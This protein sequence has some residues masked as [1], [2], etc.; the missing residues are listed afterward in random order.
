MITGALSFNSGILLF[1]DAEPAVPR[2]IPYDS[3]RIFHRSYGSNLG[4]AHSVFAA[5]ES[6]DWMRATIRRCESALDA[7]PSVHRTVDRM[8]AAVDRS[9]RELIQGD[10]DEAD[11]VFPLLIVLYSPS[12]L[13]YSLFRT[14]GGP[15]REVAGYDCQGTGA[16]LGHFLIRD[17][18]N[19]ARSL[20]DLNLTNV[21]SI[22]ADALGGIRRGQV[23][24]GEFNE[25]V[26]VYADGN[27]SRVQWM[28]EDSA[29]QRI[30][31]LTRLGRIWRSRPA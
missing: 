1:V 6:V 24:C 8:R 5:S 13:Q 27:V 14:T 15:L 9:L 17:R 25:M 3:R 21:F 29:N 10:R 22:A 30:V 26:T 2:R 28:S 31:A 4:F 11:R 12:P 20:D 23:G 19:A 16:S 7:V 18:Y